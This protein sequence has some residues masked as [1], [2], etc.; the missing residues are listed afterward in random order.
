MA[1]KRATPEAPQQS[2]QDAEPARGKRE[3]PTIDLTAAE[4]PPPGAPESAAAG[5]APKPARTS[6]RRLG[7]AAG[8]GALLVVLIAA[9][10]WRGGF[11]PV[12]VSGSGDL[13]DKVAALEKQVSDLQSRPQL[14]PAAGN[15]DALTQRIDKIEATVAKLPAGNADLTDKLTAADKAMKSLGLALT[16]LSHRTDDASANAADARKAAD[17]AAKAVADLQTSMA[18][19]AAGGAASAPGADVEALQKRVAALESQVKAAHEAIVS[20]DGSDNAARLALS[21]GVLR[22]AVVVGAP[23]ADE[24]AAVK[25]L[26]GDGAAL[27][28][29]TAFAAAGAPTARALALEL[30]ALMPQIQKIAGA[31]PPSA[32]FLA[33]LQANA[34]R[35]V[36]I[37]PVKAPQGDD[38]S[39]VLAR[40][41]VDAANADIAAALADLAKLPG[42]VRAPAASW[43][44]K[45]KA[46]QSAIE[47]ATQYAAAT[48]RALR[49]Q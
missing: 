27:T 21:A 6:M 35:L 20:N 4:L 36:R 13:K 26:G 15:L 25:Q 24:L 7:I 18:T 1:D 10:L 30:S 8:V 22:S 17:A 47:A 48:A 49:P 14:P 44:E 9:G 34:E 33:K 41:E 45:A 39:A 11:L 3:A 19:A 23:Y 12:T 46:R 37:Q 31:A 28:S 40:L 29:L 43:I 32:D 16:A 38:M 2:P 5:A 42:N